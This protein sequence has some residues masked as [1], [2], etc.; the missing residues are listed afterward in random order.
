MILIKK[1]VFTRS[2]TLALSLIVSVLAYSQTNGLVANYTLDGNALDQSTSG[3]HGTLFGTMPTTD[4]FNRP[5]QALKF[6][7]ISD[8]VRLGTSADFEQRTISV[9]F[10]ADTFPGSGAYSM[11]FSS[12]FASNKYGFTAISLSN[13]GSNN[14]NSTVGSNGKVYSNAFQNKWYHY[15]ISV[16][17]NWVKYYVNGRLID[18][19]VNN[20]FTHSGDGDTK[21]R[22]GTSRKG[23][24]FIKGAIDECKIFDRALSQVQIDSIYTF[25]PSSSCLVAHYKLDGHAADSSGNGFNGTLYGT[26]PTTDR[27]GNKNQALYFNGISD[28]VRLGTDADFAVRTISCWFKVDS[29]PGDGAYS[30][31]FSSDFATNKYGFTGISVSNTGT[32]NINSTVGNN[33]KIYASA[34]KNTWYQ[35]VIMVDGT[36]VKYYL[37][38]QLLDSFA[39]TNF[40]HSIDGDTKARLGTSRK[41]IGFL[42]GAIDDVKIYACAF[43][44]SEIVE[45]YTPGLKVKTIVSKGLIKLYPNPA[46]NKLKIEKSKT[47]Q[48][49]KVSIF[50]IDGQELLSTL[51]TDPITELDISHLAKGIY[52]VLVNGPNT[53]SA[54]KFIK[55]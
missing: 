35:Y 16:D 46:H 47:L 28:Y 51:L 3:L 8:Y 9:W 6:N 45:M 44:P 18:S 38:G 34:K 20:S 53:Y 23:V 37:N 29:F 17:L 33:G 32:N 24:G 15:V 41:G 21:A 42:K 22:L 49:Q 50:S 14:I 54:S 4:R 36:W 1:I 39:N 2:F 11:V 27:F 12:D 13:N 43:N 10:K 25:K 5:D 40:N 52:L 30:L 7:G 19:F 26:T 48:N 55:N 31:V